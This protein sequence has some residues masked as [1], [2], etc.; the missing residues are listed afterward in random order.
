MLTIFLQFS[1]T[2]QSHRRYNFFD[3]ATDRRPKKPGIAFGTTKTFLT[4]MNDVNAVRAAM[5]S[6]LDR[7]FADLEQE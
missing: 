1:F 6:S 2:L 7:E 4:K 5:R 3:H